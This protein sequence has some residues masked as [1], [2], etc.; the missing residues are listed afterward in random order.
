MA[1]LNAAKKILKALGLPPA[2][3]TDVA[4]YTL[5]ALAN[6]GPKSA[7]LDAKRRPIHIRGVL[8]FISEI[9]GK[10]YADRETIRRQVIHQLEQARVVDQNPG[11]PGLATNSPRTR[12]AISEAALLVVRSYG[13]T[14]FGKEARAFTDT[15]GSLLAVYTA[16]KN[17]QMVPLV[18][19]DGTAVML[20]PGKHNELQVAVIK[21]FAERFAPGS[22]LLYLGDTA[23][24]SLVVAEGALSKLGFPMTKHDKLPDVVLYLEKRNWLFLIEAVTSHGPVSPKRHFELEKE[25]SRCTAERIYVSAFPD[26]KEFKRHSDNIAWET[27]VWI[28]ENPDH[29]IHFNGNKFLGSP[30]Q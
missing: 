21:E 4:A 26:F 16:T 20:S 6:L 29:M 13:T 30:M 19:A 2:Q 25:L 8:E 17:M 28:A 27:E 7:W 9:F 15:H 18:L 1:T 23:K 22:A 5:L 14:T 12:Y 11:E 10:R 3:Q 24:K